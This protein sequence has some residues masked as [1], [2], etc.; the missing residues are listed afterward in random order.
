MKEIHYG[1][2]TAF[3]HIYRMSGETMRKEFNI[4]LSKFMSWMKRTVTSQKAESGESLDEGRKYMIYEV[5][6]KLC[7]FLFEE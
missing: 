1:V 5:Y 7:E 2:R 4:E 6:K 3:V